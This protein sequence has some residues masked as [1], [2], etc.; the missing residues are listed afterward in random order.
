M[1]TL[2]TIPYS[3][4]CERARWALDYCGVPYT[5]AG[6]APFFH[7]YHNRKA[8]AMRTVPA[9]VTP[10][11]IINGSDQI[12]HFA[13][14][15]APTGVSLYPK[16][17]EQSVR[18]WESRFD[19]GFGIKCRVWAYIYLQEAPEIIHEIL[20][21]GTPSEYRFLKPVVPQALNAIVRLYKAYPHRLHRI[22]K[23]LEALL[24]QCD[25][26]LRDQRPF[27]MGNHFSAV[28]ITLGAL[29]GVLVLPPE[30]GFRYPDLKNYP[31]AMQQRILQWRERPVGQ[32]ILRMYANHRTS[33]S[34]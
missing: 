7:A 30:Y 19:N 1:H 29:A 12:M 26:M 9:L 6:H 33:F 27:F 10:Q 3:H 4:Y 23:E 21:Q 31:E 14:Q 20:S 18:S 24:D 34:V 22:E 25:F 15:N 16:D 2:L 17:Q 5:E 8:G 13:Q 28:D 32:Y 11:G